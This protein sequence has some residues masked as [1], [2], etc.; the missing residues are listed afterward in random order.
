MNYSLIAFPILLFVI[1]NVIVLLVSLCSLS[2]HCIS[3]CNC[4]RILTCQ[5]QSQLR[6]LHQ[7]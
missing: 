3:N 5:E 6:A 1:S 4:Q 7:G 2:V